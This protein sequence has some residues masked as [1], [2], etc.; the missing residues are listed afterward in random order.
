MVEEQKQRER[1]LIKQNLIVEEEAKK[2]AEQ[3]NKE[4]KIHTAIKVKEGEYERG[5]KYKEALDKESQ[6]LEELR[7][8]ELI[9]KNKKILEEEGKKKVI[10]NATEDE[11]VV[12][13]VKELAKQ[14]DI[15]LKRNAEKRRMD[16]QIKD[17]IIQDKINKN[18]VLF[19][20][21]NREMKIINDEHENIINSIN[22]EDEIEIG[23]TVNMAEASKDNPN[24]E[25]LNPV[26]HEFSEKLKRDK[27]AEEA[28]YKAVKQN[29]YNR[30]FGPPGAAPVD[31][32]AAAA[33]ASAPVD[34]SAA[35]PVD[36]SAAAP[37]DPS[38]A[39]LP[40]QMSGK[41][42]L[43]M[44]RKLLRRVKHNIKPKSKS[45]SKTKSTTKPKSKSKSKSKSKK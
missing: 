32:A 9:E 6:L 2:R 34:P 29:V 41:Y 44:K 4:N 21:Y 27:S 28:R 43:K 20:E 24:T 10:A 23:Q 25:I 15:E 19:D 45:K 12:K 22:D 35:A 11:N 37:V 5:F 3:F 18:S 36:P 40:D 33:A 42:K 14:K 30:F 16:E 1:D 38:A 13:H 26:I 31:P 17:I 8:G 7:I 39:P